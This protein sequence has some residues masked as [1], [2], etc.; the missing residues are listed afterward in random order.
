MIYHY[1]IIQGTTEWHEIRRGRFTASNF[2]K[3]FMAPSTKGYNDNIN[4]VVFERLTGTIPESYSNEWMQRGTEL[5]PDAR[6]AYQLE[7]FTKV[8][9]VGFVELDDWIGCSPDGL[10]GDDGLLQIKCPKYS[11]LIDYHLTGNI[12]RDYEMQLQGEMFV[13]NRAY[14]IFYAWHPQLRPFSKVYKRDENAIA[15]IQAK[16]G[17]VIEQAK[18]RIEILSNGKKAS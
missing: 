13:T 17:E 14:N 5:E 1:D 6:M 2:G 15:D 12:G 16:L 9:Q 10:I 7:T 8:N 18:K 4:D 11:A 3:L